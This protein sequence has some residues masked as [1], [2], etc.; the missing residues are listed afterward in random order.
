MSA[1]VQLSGDFRVHPLLARRND[2]FERDTR[3]PDGFLCYGWRRV[4]KGGFIRFQHNRHYHEC[5]KDLVG[6]YVYA[7]IDDPWGAQVNIDAIDEKGRRWGQG[8]FLE[9]DGLEDQPEPTNG[10][11]HD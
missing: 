5:L 2:R 4:C 9:A 6:E 7:R 8:I 1:W 10:D 3:C 11:A